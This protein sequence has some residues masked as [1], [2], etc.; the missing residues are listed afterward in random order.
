MNKNNNNTPIPPDFFLYKDSK[1]YIFNKIVGLT[2]DKIAQLFG[3]GRNRATKHLKNIYKSGELS[4]EATFAKIAQV[5]TEVKDRLQD[6]LN[7][8]IS[9]P[10]YP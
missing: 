7:F 9:T 10:S 2:Q 3:V 5:Q 8:T 6:R 4:K 1:N